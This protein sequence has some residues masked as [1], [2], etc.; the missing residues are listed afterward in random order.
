MDTGAVQLDS[1]GHVFKGFPR[2]SG[3]TY[4]SIVPCA[5]EFSRDQSGYDWTKDMGLCRQFMPN[6]RGL[7]SLHA[8]MGITF[9][10]EAMRKLYPTARPARFQAVAGIGDGQP[11]N[12]SARRIADFW[13]FIDGRL[14]F[15]RVRFNPR[16]GAVDVNVGIGADDRFLTLVS[17]DGGDVSR[18]GWDAIQFGWV[19]FGDPVLQMVAVG[20]EESPGKGAKPVERDSATNP[21]KRN[22]KE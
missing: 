15:S 17:T 6:G 19:I 1:A 13:V 18:G 14:K 3:T 20:P 2:T 11:W 21:D 9:N 10:L 22:R 12:S 16:Q 4:G 5:G 7:L 8:N